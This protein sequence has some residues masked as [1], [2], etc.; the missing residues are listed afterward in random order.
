MMR[1]FMLAICLS[2]C[3]VSVPATVGATNPYGGVDCSKAPD[4]TVCNENSGKDPLTGNNGVLADVTK[5]IAF[6]AG[7]AAII[8]ILMSAMRFALSGSDISTNSRTDT[9]V[10]SARHTLVNALIGLAIIV[11]ARQ[12]IL[13]VLGKT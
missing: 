7:V 6:I 9:D 8:V 11:M 4:S 10:E 1:R 12:L 3:L 13:F 5:V 2:L